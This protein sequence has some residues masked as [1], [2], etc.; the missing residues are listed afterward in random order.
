MRAV[1]IAVGLSAIAVLLLGDSVIGLIPQPVVA[2]LLGFIAISFV[3]DW[4]WDLRHR[5]SHAELALAGVVALSIPVFGFLTGVGFGLV[6]TAGWFV[7]PVQPDQ[8]CPAD[9]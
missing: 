2:G 4:T 5:I 9:S 1:P 8:R 7:V 6:L 3:F